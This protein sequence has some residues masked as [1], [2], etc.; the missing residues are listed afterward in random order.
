MPDQLD[1]LI[2]LDADGVEPFLAPVVRQAQVA[3]QHVLGALEPVEADDG[4]SGRFRMT[5][6]YSIEDA[7]MLRNA[8]AR[9]EENQ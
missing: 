2:V 8:A 7:Q 4:S 3:R 9:E 6:R 1:G 5:G